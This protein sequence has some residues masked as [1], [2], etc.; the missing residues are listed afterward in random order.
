MINFS[1]LYTKC[2]LIKSFILLLF[3]ASQ[4]ISYGQ[5]IEKNN[6]VKKYWVFFSDKNGVSYNPKLFFDKKAVLRRK[7]LNI[8]FNEQDKPV[9]EQYLNDLQKIT[10]SIKHVSR[11]YNAASVY[12]S[13]EKAKQIDSLCFV[14][15][16]RL[17][18]DKTHICSDSLLPY[19]GFYE[20]NLLQKQTYRL[21]GHLFKKAGI[22]GKGV[23]IAIFDGGFPDVDIHPAFEHIRENDRIIA[24][25][26][27]A[28]NNIYVY[29]SISHGT[30]V[31]SC[32]AGIADG[33]NMGLATD[34]EFLLARTEIVDEVE[35]EEDNW[36]VALEWA[37]KHGADIINSSLGYTHHRYYPEDMNGKSLIAKAA[38]LASEKGILIVNSAGNSGDSKWSTLCTPAD[39]K[40]ILTVGGIAPETDFH[41]SFSSYGNTYTETNKPNVCAYG[42]AIVANTIGYNLKPASGTSF[43]SPLV[44]GFAACAM[45]TDTT[46]FGQ[47]LLK[48]IEKSADMYPYYDYV[49]GY[50]VPQASYFLNDS[51]KQKTKETFTY[52]IKNKQLIITV[53]SNSYENPNEN[54]L[55]YYHIA[56]EDGKLLEYNVIYV[57]SDEPLNIDMSNLPKRHTIRIHYKGYT[58]NFYIK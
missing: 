57:F 53:D 52:E 20:L 6:D 1:V 43:S 21:E 24:T 47:A 7:K 51:N 10:D 45:Q 31:L 36:I 56:N 17:I 40:S 54:N 28:K 12:M 11:W 42:T 14:D 9:K 58:N 22:T 30:M 25:W 38:D 55:M 46:I 50:G 15:S 26:D 44:A 33:V 18:A 23:R 34:A 39:A 5:Y 35:W 27:F 29:K 48:E 8:E 49:H 41:E 3:I 32:I 2:I 13:A 19:L 4:L 37:D 16:V